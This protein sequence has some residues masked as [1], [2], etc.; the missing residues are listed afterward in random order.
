MCVPTSVRQPRP[1]IC[2]DPLLWVCAQQGVV[3]RVLPLAEYH[4]TSFRCQGHCGAA[5]TLQHGVFVNQ[6]LS[7][8]QECV[9]VSVP[10]YQESL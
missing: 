2:S 3:S 9:P 8:Q 5:P 4:Q 10:P 1:A 6:V 7:P